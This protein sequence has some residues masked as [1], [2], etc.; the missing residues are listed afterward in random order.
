MT[1]DGLIRSAGGTGTTP[2]PDVPRRG[3]GPALTRTAALFEMFVL[4]GAQAGL[5]WTTILRKREGYR[6]AFAG[7]DPEQ[8][9][10]SARTTCLASC[11][12]RASSGTGPRSVGDR[13]RPGRARPREDRRVFD[14]RLVVRGRARAAEHASRTWRCPGRDRGVERCRRPQ[15]ARLSLRRPDHHV[16]RSCRPGMVNDH[17]V[18]CFRHAEVAAIA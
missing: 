4:E 9:R 11:S 16:T 6:A 14:A 12:T 2:V 5:S 15:E 17:P 8:S 3:V 18:D 10:R 13:Q 1:T 7:F